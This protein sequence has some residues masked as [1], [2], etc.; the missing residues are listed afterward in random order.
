MDTYYKNITQTLSY[1]GKNWE[2]PYYITSNDSIGNFLDKPF[3]TDFFIVAVCLQ[4]TLKVSVNSVKNT[5][6]KHQVFTGT[7]AS[8]IQFEEA[9]DDFKMNILFFDKFYLFK[10]F[11][12]TNLIFTLEYFRNH[13]DC[14]FPM[15]EQHAETILI[16]F[17]YL[18]QVAEKDSPYQNE[19]IKSTIFALLF[20]LAEIYL[21]HTEDRI[22]IT[23]TATGIYP[24][25]KELIQV[26]LPEEKSLDFY[27]GELCVS[28]KYLIELIKKEKN[29][30]PRHIIDEQLAK[31]AS[32]LLSDSNMTINEIADHLQ[33]SSTASFTRFF[34]R[35]TGTTPSSYQKQSNTKL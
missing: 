15:D 18:S 25:F 9:S 16:L 14:V 17:K 6:K 12:D 33:F 31:E 35:L 8:I 3:K 30:T 22:K 2:K 4:G 7:P 11:S 20:H 27:A 13:D 32:L 5:F 10:Y 28:T 21:N 26:Y 24:K 29:T 1:F 23:K 19:I 34:K